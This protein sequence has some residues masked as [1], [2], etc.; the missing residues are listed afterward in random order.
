MSPPITT[1]VD[2]TVSLS[3][4]AAEKFSFGSL[5]GAFEHSV[6]ANR[7]DGPYAS[8]EELDD[9]GFDSQTT[10]EIN[11]WATA[12]FAQENGVDQVLLGRKDAADADWTAT[13]DAIEG[14]LGGKD[15]YIL[16]TESRVKGDILK[17]AAWTEARD[18]IYIATSKEAAVL[19]GTAANVALELQAAGYHRTAYIWHALE[20]SDDGSAPA[21]GYLD[22][23]W[24]SAGGGFNLDSPNGAG[25]WCFQEIAGVPFDTLTGAQCSEI[26]DANANLFGRLKGLNFTSKGTMASGRFIDVTTSIDWLKT[27]LEENILGAFVGARTKIP[28]TSSGMNILRAVAH[29]IFDKGVSFGHLSPDSPPSIAFPKISEVSSADR[30]SRNLTATATATL[31][32]GIHKVTMAITVTP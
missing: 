30:A 13:L 16:N 6:T 29:E 7:V 5:L 20:D 2:I 22:G 28:Y 8:V 18:R 25:T 21:H 10:P 19:A 23:A 32:G 24:S 1:F 14:G 17:A 12:V 4:A 31:A 27:R 26:Y 3:A 11:A 15:F 9:A